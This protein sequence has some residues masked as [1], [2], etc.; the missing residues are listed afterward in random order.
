MQSQYIG[1]VTINETLTGLE[2]TIPSK[3]NWIVILFL[4][5]WLVAWIMGELF[6]IGAIAGFNKDVVGP[7][8]F[9]V[10]FWSMIWSAGGFFGF[11]IFFWSLL[12]REVIVFDRGQLTIDKKGDF[13][14]RSKTY[15]LTKAQNFRTIFDDIA[16]GTS[17]A[18]DRT[19]NSGGSVR[20]DYYLKTV[21]FANNLN[22][23]E[24]NAI[25]SQ[26]MEKGSLQKGI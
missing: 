21:K 19:L 1:K 16:S 6:A 9:S 20:F 24:T 7:A 3:K 11:R 25:L 8:R 13:L 12:G 22:E 18:S 17:S 5:T 14:T 2:I 23:T 4:G 26:L 10:L 15:D